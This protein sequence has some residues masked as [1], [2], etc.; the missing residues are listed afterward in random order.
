MLRPI[1]SAASSVTQ[2]GEAVFVRRSVAMNDFGT[3]DRGAH[4]GGERQP[5]AD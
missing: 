5:W 3:R 1:V 2:V 4:V